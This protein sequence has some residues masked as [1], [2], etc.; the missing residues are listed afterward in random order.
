MKHSTPRLIGKVFLLFAI[1]ILSV[2]SFAQTVIFQSGFETGDPAFLYRAGTL[3]TPVLS[4]TGGNSAAYCGKFTINGKYDGAFAT[5][6]TLNFTLNKYYSISYTYKIAT[7][8][9]SSRVYYSTTAGSYANITAGTLL[10][11]TTTNQLAYATVT[12][13]FRATAT[14][15]AYISFVSTMTANGCNSANFWIDDISI[16]EYNN[17]PCG[18]YCQAGGTSATPGSLTNV[19]F[20]TLSRASAFDG[21]V[22]TGLSTSVQRTV[23]YD[24]TVDR[25][26]TGAYNLF[27]QAWI[28]W[29]SDGDYSDAGEIV[30][31]SASSN[32]TGVVSRTVSVTIPAGAVLGL[33][34]MRVMMKYNAAPVATGCDVSTIYMDVEDYDIDINPAPTPMTY[35]SATTT[36]ANTTSVNAGSFRNEVVGLQIVTT[37]TLSPISATSFTFNTAG[38]TNAI[39]DIE[40]AQLWSTTNNAG[41]T[42]TSQVGAL[43][44]NPN[45]SFTF[46]GT[47]QLL[48]GTNYFWLT[49]DIPASATSPDVID[50]TCTSVTVAAVPRTPSVTAPAGNRPIITA[51]PMVYV[52]GTVTQNVSRSP[53][54]DT[55]HQIIGVEIV[56]S[57]AASPLSLTS[58]TFNTTGTSAVVTTN[59]ANAR[60]WSTGTSSS[61]ATTTQVGATVAVPNGVFSITPALTL[62]NG[63]NYFWLT[64][65][66]PAGAGCDPVQADAQCTSITIGGTPRVPTVTAPLGAVVIDCLAAYYSKG[67]LPANIPGNWNSLRDGTGANATTFGATSMFYVQNGHTMTTTAAVTIP[68]MTI[69][70]GGRVNASFL[71][72]LTDLRINSYGIFEQIVQAT[73]GGYITNFYIENYGTWIHNNAGFLPNLNRYFSPR[74]NQWFYQWG[75]GTFPSGTSWGNVLLNGT[76]TGNFGMGN[77]LTTIQGDFEWRRIGT[78]NYLLDEQNETID[79]G[80]NLIFSGGWWKVAYD[81]SNPG[82]Q[83]RTV[84]INVAGDFIMTSGKLEDYTRG[85][86]PSGATLNVSGNVTI[87][88]G[89]MNFNLSPG[90]ASPVNL[91]VGTPS[92]NWSQ[93][94]GTVT[95]GNTNVKSGKTAYMTGSKLGD[96]ASSRTM[97]VE[98]GATLYTSNYPVSGGGNFTLQTG[99]WLGI[100]SAAGIT[101]TGASGNIQTSGTRSYNS[102][103]TYEY[104]EGLSPQ[105]SGNFITTTTSGLYPSQVANLIIN[106]S[107]PAQIVNLTNT[108]NVTGT[109]TLT[110]GVLTTSIVAAT[111]PWVRIPASATVSPVG[112]SA[113]SYVDG[114]VRRQGAT[115]FTFPTGNAGKWRR[116]AFTAPSA[117]T[118]FE[119]RYVSSAYSNTTSMAIAPLTVLDH[120]STIEHWY[121]DKPLG[122][123][124]ATTKVQLFWEDAS[125]SGVYKFDSLGVA[126]WSGSAWEN[127]NCYGSCPPNWSTSTPQRT[128]TG[129]ASGTGIGTIQSNTVSVYGPFTLSSIGFFPLNPL[130]VSLVSFNATCE[131]EFVKLQWSTA[132]ELNNNFFTVEK[133]K[134]G[135]DFYEL[136]RVNGGGNSNNLLRYS[137]DDRNKESG[138]NYYRLSQTDFDGTNVQLNTISVK[139]SGNLNTV[140][141]AYNNH[142]GKIVIL[143]DLDSEESLT[144]QLYD[145]LGQ[146]IRFGK[147]NSTKGV[148]THF[149]DITGLSAGIYLLNIHGSEKLVTK[150]IVVN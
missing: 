128:Y 39:N 149:L 10:S 131:S 85:G 118:E 48:Q 77:C 143:S 54:P 129:S 36:Q 40:N 6:T 67:N 62:V 33:T 107:G 43:I 65:D 72:S 95:L 138:V 87:T 122:A 81:N 106:K 84:V 88:G 139:C 51:T 2:N 59:I 136:T 52:S 144:A 9:G 124:G 14:Q 126:R 82:N 64:Y 18:Y 50:A 5:G 90:G 142:S 83:T 103:A 111:A 21:Y 86:A 93:T 57:G 68:F 91:V 76:T 41:F 121:L 145:A 79:I 140:I 31:P 20:N 58:F 147:Y 1:T 101:S 11:T 7:C 125:M 130:P 13:T 25:N 44:A 134:N 49:Y 117:T 123:D 61:F 46:T 35:I 17:P 42:T 150:K 102:G 70:A 16:T 135:F 45:G 99:A 47:V 113:N 74:S 137:Y 115:A 119:A 104:Y 3:N 30:M 100:G 73:N 38:T 120:V 15:A 19:V 92:M 105:V 80:G 127:A 116:I 66:I 34:K 28:D 4:T 24:L 109:L 89:T 22:C 78:N 112:G 132:A 75:G 12:T 94:G 146:Q 23:S 60:L 108:T 98:A 55:N 26:A 71:M 96:I 133:S 29:N 110:N 114:Y 53:R 141:T 69:E 56:T 27:T 8:G 32:V 37:G 63:T 97:T 148:S